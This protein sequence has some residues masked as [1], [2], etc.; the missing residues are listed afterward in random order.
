MVAL[1]ARS[2]GRS[3]EIS[4][5]TA[6]VDAVARSLPLRA[7]SYFRS[8][9]GAALGLGMTAR[10]FPP[11]WSVEDACF[12]VSWASSSRDILKN[13]HRNSK[14]LMNYYNS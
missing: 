12:I 9:R 6:V 8:L 4:S 13:I 7:Q 3:T 5:Q 2:S 14:G 11:P 1:A 10:R